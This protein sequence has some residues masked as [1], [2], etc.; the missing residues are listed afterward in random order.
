[1]KKKTAYA[2]RSF[3]DGPDVNAPQVRRGDKI[4]V[5]EDRYND[6]KENGL[7]ADSPPPARARPRESGAR[8]RRRTQAMRSP[9]EGSADDDRE[10]EPEEALEVLKRHGL[11]PEHV[12]IAE[13]RDD[14]ERAKARATDPP[15]DDKPA[16]DAEQKPAAGEGENAEEKPAEDT[17]KPAEGDAAAGEN[18]PKRGNRAS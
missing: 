6:L 5:D 17:P 7:I 3:N 14:A 13:L 10:I 18:R 2:V 9:A 4:T 1:M 15:D 12:T 16:T 11:A 8:T